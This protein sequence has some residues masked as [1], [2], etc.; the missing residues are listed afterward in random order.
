[1][2][3]WTFGSMALNNFYTVFKHSGEVSADTVSLVPVVVDGQQ[4]KS[5]VAENNDWNLIESLYCKGCSLEG[6]V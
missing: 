6:H 1:M 5:S 4:M 3:Y 2:D